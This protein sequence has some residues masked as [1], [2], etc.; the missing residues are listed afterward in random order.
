MTTLQFVIIL[1]VKND[2]FAVIPVTN[3]TTLG[4][5]EKDCVQ[6]CCIL[7]IPERGID[8]IIY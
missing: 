1:G 2:D 3:D 5:F 6:Q 7:C 8:K 4:P